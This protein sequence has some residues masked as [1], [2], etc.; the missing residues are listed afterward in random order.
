MFFTN[1][2]PKALLSPQRQ[3]RQKIWHQTL[4]LLPWLPK[5]HLI[6]SIHEH[7]LV[8]GPM[9]PKWLWTWFWKLHFHQTNQSLH[10][11]SKQF[12]LVICWCHNKL[13]K[14][15]MNQHIS[16]VISRLFHADDESRDPPLIFLPLV[17][18]AELIQLTETS[19]RRWTELDFITT[20]GSVQL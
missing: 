16:R 12:N 4:I 11:E 15:I 17:R 13:N 20:S 5:Q 3:N 6:G 1:S 7:E 19:S 18:E 8:S 9:C 14:S 2:F 10:S